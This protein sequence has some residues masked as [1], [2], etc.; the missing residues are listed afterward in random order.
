MVGNKTDAKENSQRRAIIMRHLEKIAIP[1]NPEPRFLRKTSPAICDS[2]LHRAATHPKRGP[3]S[4]ACGDLVFA[5]VRSRYCDVGC[6]L[7]SKAL[8][9]KCE[10]GVGGREV[11]S[12][13]HPADPP[14]C[15]KSIRRCN[16]VCGHSLTRYACPILKNKT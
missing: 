9:G 7:R 2:L 4:L 10:R 14:K 5:S 16:F 3:S 1:W 6:A 12:C 15:I 11:I 8:Y 13:P